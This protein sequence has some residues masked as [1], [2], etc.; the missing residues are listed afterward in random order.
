M[1][2]LADPEAKELLSREPKAALRPRPAPE[3]DSGREQHDAAG[4]QSD[5][6]IVSEVRAYM[7][8]HKLTQ[9]TVVNETRI[10]H[11]SISK[12]L[13]NKYDGN[14]DKVDAVM[15][16]WLSARKAG[17]VAKLHPDAPSPLS[18]PSQLARPRVRG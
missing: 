10:D 12:W 16:K 1:P 2:L 14:N 4:E 3:R 8:L 11:G 5:G 9:T 13:A 6:S 17:I 7:K 18:R 15:R